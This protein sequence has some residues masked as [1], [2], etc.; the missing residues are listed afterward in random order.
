L[1]TYFDE[2]KGTGILST[3][4]AEGRVDSAVYARPRIIDEDTAAFIM[5]ERLTYHNIGRNP[6]AS[7]LFIEEG[8]GYKGV[9]LY[10]EKIREDQ[11]PELMAD[12]SRR[13]LSEPRKRS[14]AHCLLQS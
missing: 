11:D 4:D 2:K 3:A 12:M 9:R 6:Y 8:Q 5:R 10:L 7:Y 14:Q 13:C 1:G